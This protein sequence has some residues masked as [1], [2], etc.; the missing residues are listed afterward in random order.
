M[1]PTYTRNDTGSAQVAASPFRYYVGYL[2]PAT[3]AVGGFEIGRAEPTSN[4]DDVVAVQDVIQSNGRPGAVVIGFSR[5]E[6]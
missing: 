4:L 3:G 1:K 2:D 5:F 6:D